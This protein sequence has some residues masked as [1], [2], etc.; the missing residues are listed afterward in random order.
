VVGLVTGL[1]LLPIALLGAAYGNVQPLVVLGLLVA[2]RSRAGPLLV[3]V[4]ASLKFV[5]IVMIAVDLG[6]GR[7]QRAAWTTAFTASL[8]LPMLLFDLSGY[9]LEIG[10]AQVALTE[11]SWSLWAVG[12]M[13]AVAVAVFLARTRFAWLAA[14]VAMVLILPR[15]LVYQFSF[16]LVGLA[17][18]EMPSPVSSADGTRQQ[19]GGDG[20]QDGQ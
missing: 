1:F 4:A 11:W 5:P 20:R 19:Q 16:L 12:A 2:P 15:L 17:R 14:G 8:L 18:G 7:W 3:A 10:H 13:A 9:S 6:V